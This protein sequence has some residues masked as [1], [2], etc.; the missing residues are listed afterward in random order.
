MVSKS[1]TGQAEWSQAEQDQL[2]AMILRNLAS[3]CPV[4][5]LDVRDGTCV[6]SQ[7]TSVSA[8][9]TQVVVLVGKE[10]DEYLVASVCPT[11][12][13]TCE[14]TGRVV[15]SQSFYENGD[16]KSVIYKDCN[17]CGGKGVL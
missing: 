7:S 4:Q 14:S 8:S 10:A 16:Q 12:C 2:R 9:T 11:K 6:V 15:T 17:R 13:P 5:Q 1:I 3:S